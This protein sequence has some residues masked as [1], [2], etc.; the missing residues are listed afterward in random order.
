MLRIQ[1]FSQSVVCFGRLR[2][3]TMSL[4]ALPFD[5]YSIIFT[6]FSLGETQL[7]VCVVPTFRALFLCDFYSGFEPSEC[8]FHV[9]VTGSLAISRDI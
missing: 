8:C 9:L 7:C 6:G 2:R 1:S 5:L 3:R 4:D